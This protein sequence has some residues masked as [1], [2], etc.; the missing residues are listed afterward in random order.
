MSPS[1]PL[2]EWALALLVALMFAW[3]A[4]GQWD[5]DEL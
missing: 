1:I 2:G 5:G 4:W 3:L